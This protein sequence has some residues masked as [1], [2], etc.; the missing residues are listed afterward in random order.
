MSAAVADVARSLTTRPLGI[1]TGADPEHLLQD[2]IGASIGDPSTALVRSRTEGL[3]PRPAAVLEVVIP[4]LNEARRLPETL[5]RTVAFLRL[6]PWSARVL[7]VDNGSCDDT[8][9][10]AR[11]LA[12]TL[13]GPVPVEVVGCARPGKGAAVRRGLLSS[14]S[15]YVGFFDADLA[16]PVETL[17]AVMAQLRGG[18]AAVIGSRHAPGAMVLGAQPRLRRLGGSAFRRL[19]RTVVDG[20]HDTQCGFKFFERHAVMRALVQCQSSGFAFDVELLQHLKADGAAIVELPVSW[21]D[22]P[23]STF[24]PLRDGPASFTAVLQMQRRAK[25][26]T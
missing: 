12:Q 15:R 5:R 11:R 7:V 6:Q 8:S 24:H 13:G 2:P 23:Q 14:R 21:T 3:P 4:A 22:Q 9:G 1:P 16:T 26:L 17:G 10:V 19:V 20:V 18:A 25:Y